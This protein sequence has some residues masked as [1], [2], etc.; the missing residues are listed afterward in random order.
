MSEA[1]FAVE[2]DNMARCMAWAMED[3]ENMTVEGNLVAFRQKPVWAEIAHGHWDAE[4][5]RLCLK[6]LQQWKIILVWTDNRYVQGLSQLVGSARMV[7]V[8]M[9]EP[10]L[11]DLQAISRDRIEDVRNISSGINDNADL[12]VFIE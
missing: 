5:L 4:H 12:A 3:F 1:G 6:P 10:D 8:S 7:D 2:V 9:R 11:L